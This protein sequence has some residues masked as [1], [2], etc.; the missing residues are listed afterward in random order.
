[1]KE[2][3]MQ[4]NINKQITAFKLRRPILKTEKLEKINSKKERK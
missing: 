4:G 2:S 3:K 1:M